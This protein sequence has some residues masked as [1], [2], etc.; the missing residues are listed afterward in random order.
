MHGHT[1]IVVV[2]MEHVFGIGYDAANVAF[3][4]IEVIDEVPDLADW[5]WSSYYYYY[6]PEHS[7]GPDMPVDPINHILGLLHGM[8]TLFSCKQ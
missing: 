2:C 4:D 3:L 1:F 6:D 5:D 8:F 7:L